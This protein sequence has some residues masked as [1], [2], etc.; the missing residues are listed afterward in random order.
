MR[1]WE[2]R[3]AFTEDIRTAQQVGRMGGWGDNLRGIKIVSA[4]AQGRGG[5]KGAI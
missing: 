2:A 1:D 5:N 4:G 3:K